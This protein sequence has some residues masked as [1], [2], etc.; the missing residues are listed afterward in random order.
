MRQVVPSQVALLSASLAAASALQRLKLVTA[1]KG[2]EKLQDPA[3]HQTSAPFQNHSLLR[4]IPAQQ[5]ARQSRRLSDAC[6]MAQVS[7][8]H[9]VSVKE[10]VAR[11]RRVQADWLW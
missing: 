9:Q 6:L 2:T 7:G 4:S 11:M 3:L 5:R 8:S 1:D 10:V